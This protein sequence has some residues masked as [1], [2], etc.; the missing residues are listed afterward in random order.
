MSSLWKYSIPVDAEKARSTGCFTSLPIRIHSRNDIADEATRQS[1]EDWGKS[2]GDGWEKVSGSS[3]SEV[4]NWGAFIFPEAQLDRLATTTY[5][6]NLG[7]IHD[8][9]CD[10]L[11]YEEAVAE[12]A[13]LSNAMDV[14]ST[15]DTQA[16]SNDRTKRL[17]QCVGKALLVAMDT[18]RP[19]AL[20]MIDSYRKKWLDVMEP[21]N[22]EDI[23]SLDEYLIFRNL[24][25]GM[26]AYWLLVKYGMAV[27]ISEEEELRIRHIFQA[28]EAALVL[29]NDYWSWDREWRAALKARDPRIVN[30]IEVFMRTE[31]KTMEEARQAVHDHIIAYES[32]YLER[33]EEFYST[34]QNIPDYLRLYIEVCGSVVAGNHYWCANCPR[35]HAWRELEQ[36]STEDLRGSSANNIETS[37][38]SNISSDVESSE[39]THEGLSRTVSSSSRD[40][41]SSSSLSSTS[42]MIESLDV[43]FDVPGPSLY[44][45]KRMIDTI[46]QA[47][48]IMDD[49]EDGSTL[50]RGFPATHSV[51]GRGQS[52][53]SANFMFVRA[54][55]LAQELSSRSSLQTLLDG[56]ETLMLGQSWDLQWKNSFYFPTEAEY[57]EMIEN[58]TGGLFDMLLGLMA[59]ESPSSLIPDGAKACFKQMGKVFGQFFQIRDDFMNL[60]SAEYTEQKGFCEDFDEGKLSYP[61]VRLVQHDLVSRDRVMGILRQHLLRTGSGDCATMPKETKTYLLRCMARAGVFEATVQKLN[62]LENKICEAIN[63]LE[64]KFEQENPMLRLLVARLSVKDSGVAWKQYL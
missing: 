49:I 64:H 47:S 25:G 11:D 19:R 3:W 56:L 41:E 59:H 29:T 33:K 43:W 51:Y 48:L 30:A 14:E 61:L 26:E 35:H 20:E 50:R 22:I 60:C 2:V 16:K 54:V 6:A 34:S 8:D 42:L 63:A 55:K 1:I 23:Q 62:D 45:I 40:A 39:P 5:L 10:E 13:K 12:H 53:N 31:G 37:R 17:K 46:H 15:D 7:N 24:N 36:I 52:V 18:D 38:L 21:Q 4:G 58:K 28:A 9:L 32:Q 27:T 44:I 57:L